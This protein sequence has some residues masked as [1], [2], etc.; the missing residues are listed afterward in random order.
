MAANY[1]G[2]AND[3]VLLGR[4]IAAATTVFEAGALLCGAG[5]VIL[6]SVRTVTER[7]QAG[8]TVEAI[9]QRGEALAGPA[10]LEH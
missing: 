9:R 7:D 4:W 6:D 3:Q 5:G 10:P 1:E 8:F 2:T